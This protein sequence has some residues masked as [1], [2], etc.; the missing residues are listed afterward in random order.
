MKRLRQRL[1]G[2]LVDELERCEMLGIPYLIAHPG[3]HVGSGRGDRNQDHRAVDR[4]GPSGP[5]P[6]YKV[7]VALELTAGQGGDLGPQL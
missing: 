3:S 5:A 6:A 4:R 7:Q 2:G 1:I